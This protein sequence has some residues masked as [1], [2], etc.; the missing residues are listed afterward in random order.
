M[1]GAP[2]DRLASKRSDFA[3][4][5][6]RTGWDSGACYA[7][8]SSEA[9]DHRTPDRYS[10]IASGWK[11]STPPMRR[12]RSNFRSQSLYT[13]AELTPSELADFADRQQALMRPWIGR[14]FAHHRRTKRPSQRIHCLLRHPNGPG[15][16]ARN[17]RRLGSGASRGYAMGFLFGRFGTRGRRFK[18]CLPDFQ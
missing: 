5:W 11:R 18:S 1:L 14:K 9:R 4:R 8:R 7:R 13:R 17:F 6:R 10:L 15:Q 16:L 2:S 12:L 3:G